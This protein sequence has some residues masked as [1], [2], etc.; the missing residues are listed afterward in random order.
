MCRQEKVS[1][2]RLTFGGGGVQEKERARRGCVHTEGTGARGLSTCRSGCYVCV[3][4]LRREIVRD[5]VTRV[6]MLSKET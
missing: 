6:S 4:K 1:A 2:V 5:V 3:C